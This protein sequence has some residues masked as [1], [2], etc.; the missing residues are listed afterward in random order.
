PLERA[1][2]SPPRGTPCAC[3]KVSSRLRPRCAFSTMSCSN[4]G[5]GTAPTSPMAKTAGSSTRKA[6]PS[7]LLSNLRASRSAVSNVAFMRS[8]CSIGTRMV[9]NPMAISHSCARRRP[10]AQLGEALGVSPFRAGPAGERSAPRSLSSIMQTGRP[11]RS[12]AARLPDERVALLPLRCVHGARRR[13]QLQHGRALALA[14]PG[15][16][17][18]F[19]VGELQRIVVHPRLA[20]VDLPEPS[21][22]RP[23]LDVREESKK[24]LVA[25][26]LFERDL[27]AG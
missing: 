19:P 3:M 26:F 24:A 27:R 1:F 20:L 8:C 13:R 16:Q 21:H 9:L 2:A 4:A 6:N 23:E 11:A 18:G 14:Q 15:E 25:D 22:L 10:R 5:I 17:H 12:R 7:M